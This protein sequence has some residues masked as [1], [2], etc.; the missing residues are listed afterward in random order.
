ML[1]FFYTLVAQ[2]EEQEPSK[3]KVVGSSPA[4]S[5]L[6]TIYYYNETCASFGFKLPPYQTSV[7]AKSY[8]YVFSR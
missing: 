2:L 8:D 5:V 1:P 3:L 4:E 6:L 7:L